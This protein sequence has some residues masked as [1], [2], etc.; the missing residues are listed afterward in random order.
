[1]TQAEG[2]VVTKCVQGINH[3]LTHHG[4]KL[5][6]YEKEFL[7]SCISG[8]ESMCDTKVQKAQELV[9]KGQRWKRAQTAPIQTSMFDEEGN[10]V[11]DAEE[12]ARAKE[13]KKAEKQKA[14]EAKGKGKN[15]NVVDLSARRAQNNGPGVDIKDGEQLALTEQG[16][17]TSPSGT[18]MTW[19][20]TPGVPKAVE[21]G[22]VQAV[23]DEGNQKKAIKAVAK[24]TKLEETEIGGYWDK[25]VDNGRLELVE[26]NGKK[27]WVAN[28]PQDQ[29]VA[30]VS[31]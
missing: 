23:Q 28:L 5:D 8:A 6:A 9:V 24:A 2:A 3:I 19:R 22:L 25:L 30:A 31:G 18:I 27:H 12:K 16:E 26:A 29:P 21:M 17:I 15:G 10:F 1:M 14:K 11:E 4:S 7:R 20:L 13:A